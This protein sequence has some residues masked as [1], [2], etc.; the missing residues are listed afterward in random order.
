MAHMP[1]FKASEE[2]FMGPFGGLAV[3]NMAATTSLNKDKAFRARKAI[4]V[5]TLAA[6]FP[7]GRKIEIIQ[8]PL[9]D[10]NFMRD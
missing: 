3:L 9:R 6:T 2:G 4:N 1:V 10:W 7:K 8:D 5:L